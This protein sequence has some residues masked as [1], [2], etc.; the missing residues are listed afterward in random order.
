[1]VFPIT[2]G[3]HKKLTWHRTAC[4]NRG[5][6]SSR[7]EKKEHTAVIV[8]GMAGTG[9]KRYVRDWGWQS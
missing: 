3:D 7:G 5:P 9:T 8:A 1:M 6:F 2:Y 4:S